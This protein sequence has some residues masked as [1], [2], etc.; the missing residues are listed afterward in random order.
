MTRP[1]PKRQKGYILLPVSYRE[2]EDAI[3]ARE[4]G[5]HWAR[6]MGFSAQRFSW[7]PFVRYLVKRYRETEGLDVG[8]DSDGKE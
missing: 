7:S 2:E 6:R 8:R 5:E 3:L 4:A 1:V